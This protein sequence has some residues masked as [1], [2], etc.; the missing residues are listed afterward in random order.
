MC[1]NLFVLLFLVTLCFV[2]AVQR[3]ME[4]IPIKKKTIT[5]CHVTAINIWS[6]SKSFENLFSSLTL[7][8]ASWLSF[9]YTERELTIFNM[10]YWMH[11]SK[12]F[13]E[14]FSTVCARKRDGRIIIILLFQNL[15][16][17]DWSQKNHSHLLLWFS[18][19]KVLLIFILHASSCLLVLSDME[20]S[21]SLNLPS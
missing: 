8:R 14:T 12:T 16:N 10:K 9:L 17:L 18:Q 11:C 20:F 15:S 4:W 13:C 5:K 3:C 19:V 7:W 1:S 21:T 6:T 2:V